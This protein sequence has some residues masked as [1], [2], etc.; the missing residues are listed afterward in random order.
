MKD[1]VVP[2]RQI[3]RL[4][5]EFVT[6]DE[7]STYLRVRAMLHQKGI[8]QR[9][10]VFGSDIKTKKQQVVR[11]GDVL[12]AEIDAKFGG[13]GVVPKELDG[14]IVSSHY[15]LYEV[16]A[17]AA[18]LDYVRHLMR[19]PT[20][21][22][23][24]RAQGSTNYAAI[25][26]EEFISYLVPLPSIDD[27]RRVA[28]WLDSVSAAVWA[29]DTR[30]DGAD[31]GSIIRLLPP[32]IDATIN[33]ASNEIAQLGDLADFVS[34]VVHPGDDVGLAQEFVGLQH[35]EGHT[36][37]ALG[38]DPLE[39][40]KGRKFRFRP[41][42]IIYGYLRPY[43][44]KVWVADRHG[45]C[46]VDQ[47]VLR[48]R[49]GVSADFL[50][51]ELRGREA[52]STA[53]NLTHSLQLPRLRSGLL[54]AIEVAVVDKANQAALVGRLDALRNKIISAAAARRRQHELA[55]ALLPAA[56]NEVFGELN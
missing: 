51:Y 36:G 13:F 25:R 29:V 19:W 44:N 11:Q 43:Q 5:K 34:D 31:S 23:Q 37:R 26:P 39:V 2:L 10:E 52:L 4:R 3:L 17:H 9:D 49:P 24:V 53:I 21:A 35:I 33:K 32:M 55:A 45:L 50:A 40:M 6:I 56:L 15:F 18:D 41:G 22:R 16:D 28:A 47:Y 20:L 30:L 46:S 7:T 8:V 1:L 38:A 48:V 14:A 27:Q 12:V 42:D 54:S